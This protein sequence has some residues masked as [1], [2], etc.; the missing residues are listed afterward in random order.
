MSNGPRP[1]AVAAW[2]AAASSLLLLSCDERVFVARGRVESG[3]PKLTNGTTATATAGSSVTPSVD[4]ATN[5]KDCAGRPRF[6]S[7]GMFLPSVFQ[8]VQPDISKC[9][10]RAS[11]N[12]VIEAVIDRNGNVAS[13]RVVSDPITCAAQAAAEAVKQWRFCPAE[14]DGELIEA[15]MQLTVNINY[16]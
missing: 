6:T 11:G 5:T 12:P 15:T 10:G 16:R 4:V 7:S 3:T 9:A 2:V 8:R 14:R 13:V 1:L